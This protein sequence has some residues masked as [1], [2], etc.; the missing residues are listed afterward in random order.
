MIRAKQQSVSNAIEAEKKEYLLIF[1]IWPIQKL[2]LA[3]LFFGKQISTRVS[4]FCVLR[5][6]G[7]FF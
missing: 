5:W 6:A 2:I 3:Y 7:C 1:I 4:R